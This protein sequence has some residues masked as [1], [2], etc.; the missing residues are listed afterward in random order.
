[1]SHWSVVSSPS[2]FR[3]GF[4]S[5]VV[6]LLHSDNFAVQRQSS[7]VGTKIPLFRTTGVPKVEHLPVS[8]PK[9]ADPA[10][11]PDSD[12]VVDDDGLFLLDVSSHPPGLGVDRLVASNWLTI[13]FIFFFVGVI[14][15]GDHD[16]CC[17][18]I[19]R[20]SFPS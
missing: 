11:H 14:V 2:E 20:S 5:Q 12:V 9:V 8:L 3:F 10:C 17:I 13:L 16:D 6:L 18:H 4:L 1:M 19:A 15:D 7:P